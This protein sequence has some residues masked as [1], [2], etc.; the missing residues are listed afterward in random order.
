MLMLPSTGEYIHSCFTTNAIH[1][2]FT[3]INEKNILI[4]IHAFVD[5]SFTTNASRPA[6]LPM[7]RSEYE[8]SNYLPRSFPVASAPPVHSALPG[9]RGS[10][11]FPWTGR[12]RVYRVGFDGMR[13][14]ALCGN[15]RCPGDPVASP[16]EGVLK[17]VF[18]S[19]GVRTRCPGGLWDAGAELRAENLCLLLLRLICSERSGGGFNGLTPSFL[20]ILSARCFSS[21]GRTPLSEDRPPTLPFGW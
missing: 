7:N 3:L 5:T 18:G 11:T 14:P 6:S 16:R 19:V 9:A 4:L 12:E 8:V 10:L 17:W 1:H 21:T 20:L 2:D 13:D 15:S